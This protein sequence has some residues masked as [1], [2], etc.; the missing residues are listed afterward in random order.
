MELETQ[1]L[2]SEDLKYINDSTDVLEET[3]EVGR[4]LNGLIRYL[5]RKI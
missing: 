2:I 1:I 5:D 4:M 3:A